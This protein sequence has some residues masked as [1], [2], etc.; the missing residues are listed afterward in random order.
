MAKKKINLNITKYISGGWDIF[1]K[2]WQLLLQVGIVIT[3]IQFLP[4]IYRIFAG[5][6]GLA[7]ISIISSILSMVVSIGWISILIKLTSGKKA[8][9]EDLWGSVDR[10]IPYFIASIAMVIVVLVG[11]LLFIIPGFYF[12]IKY[13]FVPYLIIDKKLSVGDAFSKSSQMTD[14][15]KWQLVAFWFATFVL[16]ILGLLAF[17]VGVVITSVV[18]SL[19]YAKLYNDLKK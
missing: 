17:I 4:N 10:V 8:Q 3:L 2:N 14:G 13:M 12:A 18:T 11:L 9:L 7:L 1:Q 6:D 19:A 15:I 5:E 16:N